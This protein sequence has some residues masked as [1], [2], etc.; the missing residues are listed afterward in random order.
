MS[1]DN[2]TPRGQ[3]EAVID[4]VVVRHV[5]S[6]MAGVMCC[7]KSVLDAIEKAGGKLL[8]PVKV[9]SMRDGQHFYAHQGGFGSLEQSQH[10]TS[11]FGTP[12]YWEPEDL[13]LINVLEQQ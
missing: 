8:M 3:L 2:T 5:E 10:Y 13:V 12:G 1:E 7:G 6:G 11:F 9:G 4:G